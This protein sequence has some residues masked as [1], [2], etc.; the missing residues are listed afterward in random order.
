MIAYQGKVAVWKR[1]DH[2]CKMT[3]SL[4]NIYVPRISGERNM[5]PIFITVVW[6]APTFVKKCN[7]LLPGRQLLRCYD[8]TEA[9]DFKFLFCFY[10][11]ICLTHFMS[12]LHF[13]IP[14]K[15]KTRSPIWRIVEWIEKSWASIF[16]FM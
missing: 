16:F 7:T 13:Y 12:I 4:L 10:F 3:T 8:S 14:W 15:E 11:D 5:A 1:N 2:S 6:N 9:C